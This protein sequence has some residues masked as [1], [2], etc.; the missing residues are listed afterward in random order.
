[1]RPFRACWPSKPAAELA[2]LLHKTKPRLARARGFFA[3]LG[4]HGTPN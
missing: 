2:A 3:T 4:M 1:M